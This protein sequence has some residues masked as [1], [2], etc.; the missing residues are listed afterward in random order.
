MF[1]RRFVGS[2]ARNIDKAASPPTA[3]LQAPPHLDQDA[4]WTSDMDSILIHARFNQCLEWEDIQKRFF[5]N[6]T[7]TA[8]I[9]RRFKLKERI[10][11]L[12]RNKYPA[13]SG[14]YRSA[15]EIL[16]PQPAYPVG[17]QSV[18]DL[19]DKT[20]TKEQ[21][22]ST[23]LKLLRTVQ[24]GKKKGH[25]ERRLLNLQE[26]AF[27]D[28]DYALLGELRVHARKNT[29]TPSPTSPTQLAKGVV[30][31]DQTPEPMLS[32]KPGFGVS[33]SQARSHRETRNDGLPQ[34]TRLRRA[35]IVSALNSSID[36]SS[37]F[38][39]KDILNQYDELGKDSSALVDTPATKSIVAHY[40]ISR[41]FCGSQDSV[42]SS[43]LSVLAHR[44][45]ER[46]LDVNPLARLAR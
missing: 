40:T 5:P 23:K 45:R 37:P 8:L 4:P 32:S 10:E 42:A 34:E 26:Q 28:E 30:F 29:A 21:K 1:D 31:N 7:V 44:S 11:T 33:R 46:T 25:T 6:K 19:H 13:T 2:T 18:S 20:F 15:Q 39:M 16:H 24:E 14:Q 27:K 9:K 41:D 12:E 43:I 22:A 17:W 38:S 36:D 35:D 3:L